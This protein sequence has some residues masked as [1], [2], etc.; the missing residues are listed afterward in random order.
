MYERRLNM[1]RQGGG[2]GGGAPVLNT[3]RITAMNYDLE[4]GLALSLPLFYHTNKCC[5]C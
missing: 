2:G 5:S 4:V 1:K 3:L